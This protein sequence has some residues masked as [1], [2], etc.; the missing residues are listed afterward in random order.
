MVLLNQGLFVSVV[1]NW[2][3]KASYRCPQF[4]QAYPFGETADG[5][6]WSPVLLISSQVSLPFSL[7]LRPLGLPSIFIGLFKYGL[8]HFGQIIV[9]D[10]NKN[11]SKG[12]K[13]LVEEW[14]S[15]LCEATTIFYFPA[16][17][18]IYQSFRSYVFDIM[19]AEE[20]V[21]IVNLQYNLQS[22]TIR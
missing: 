6:S 20:K 9:S 15:W 2:F 16:Y 22:F 12:R 19:R 21:E 4:R 13:R 11:R 18:S 7:K 14:V 5:V 1:V 3:V 10:Q 8:L 17:L